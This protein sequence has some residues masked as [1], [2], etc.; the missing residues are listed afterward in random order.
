MD[1]PTHGKRLSPLLVFLFV[2]CGEDGAQLD[3]KEIKRI[4]TGGCE[5]QD[6]THHFP[7]SYL[8]DSTLSWLRKNPDGWRASQ[9]KYGCENAL[10]FA[11]G[12]IKTLDDLLI[13]NYRKSNGDFVQLVKNDPENHLSALLESQGKE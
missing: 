9:D 6:L 13:A 2:C 11:N 7:G 5:G 3:F 1:L 4:S 10:Y 12:S 8:F